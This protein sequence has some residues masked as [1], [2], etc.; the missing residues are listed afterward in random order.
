MPDR[1]QPLYLLLGE[2]LR[3]HGVRGEIRVRVLTEYP[4]RLPQMP[5][6][7]IGNS[8]EAPADRPFAIERARVQQDYALVKLSG[9]DT[10]DQAE[11]LRGQFL[12]VETKDAVPLEDDEIYL[13]E[14][15]DMTV[16]TEAGDA[17]GRLMEVIETGAN[18]VYVIDSPEY[19]EVLIPATPEV[20]L[21]VDTVTRTLTVRLLDGLLPE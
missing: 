17:L 16:V 7:Y 6:V 4:E 9:I 1:A 13:Y 2:I 3:P 20:I 21:S 15:I 18:D 11:M 8:P 5:Q 19:G 12:M 10:R 14:L